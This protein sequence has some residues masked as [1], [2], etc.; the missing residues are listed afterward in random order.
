MAAKQGLNVIALTDH[1]TVA[2]IPAMIEEAAKLGVYVI[3]GVELNSSDGHFLGL[4]VDYQDVQFL[5]FLDNVRNMRM[6]R[7]EQVVH[8]LNDFGFTINMETLQRAAKPGLPT[9]TTVARYL[10]N[11]GLFP[12]V[13]SVFSFLLGKK[14]P[15]YKSATAPDPEACVTAIQEA[16]GIVVEA[17]PHKQHENSDGPQL[18]RFY[19]R[20]IRNNVV[21]HEEMPTHNPR[22]REIATQIRMITQPAGLLEVGGSNFHGRAVSRA[23]L[24]SGAVGGDVLEQL[25]ERL[26]DHCMH[27][28]FFKR[29]R[30]RAQNLTPEEFHSSLR[31]REIRLPD[32]ELVHLVERP[33]L[34]NFLLDPGRACPF[35]IMGPAA[36]DFEDT[37]LEAFKNAGV[38]IMTMQTVKGYYELAWDLYGTHSG[39]AK[40]KERDL[41]RFNLERHLFGARGDMCRIAFFE[42]PAG[43]DLNSLKVHVRREIGP[44][45]FYRVRYRSLGDTC[46]SSFI[47]LPSEDEVPSQCH[48]LRE[49]GIDPPVRGEPVPAGL[50][51]T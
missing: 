32:L 20:L 18:R 44:L 11:Q 2:G 49:H 42:P 41:L 1:G 36:L 46:F 14:S 24:G 7:I 43:L 10:V 51:T 16:G 30:W 33:P 5:N 34:A 39:T 50:Q 37:V 21:G 29:M 13:E 23:V 25:M 6:G 38:N 28:D 26:P 12:D 27:K 47:H 48:R 9:R 8:M 22:F 3:P 45:K 19:S 15:V 31:P 17:H 40:E 35:V 4:F